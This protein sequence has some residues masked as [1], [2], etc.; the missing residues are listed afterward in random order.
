MYV[1]S[2]KNKISVTDAEYSDTMDLCYKLLFVCVIL[3]FMSVVVE[4]PNTMH[5]DNVGA[6]LLS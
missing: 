2:E 1:K 6:I 4:F 3:L 5:I